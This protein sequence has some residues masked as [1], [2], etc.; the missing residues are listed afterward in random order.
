[1]HLE[2]GSAEGLVGYLDSM[3]FWSK[4]EVEDLSASYALVL[5]PSPVRGRAA[6]A[7]RRSVPSPSCPAPT[8]RRC[9]RQPS[10]PGSG[11][12]RRCASPRAG[13]GS[14]ARPTTARSPTS[15]AG[16]RR[17]CTWTRAATA[18]R[19]RWRGC[20]TWGARRAGW[21]CCTSTAP[22]RCCPRTATPSILDDRTI[23]TVTTSA[24]HYELGPIALALVKRSTPA[25]ATSRRRRCRRGPGGRRRGLSRWPGLTSPGRRS[26][27]RR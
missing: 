18:A 23:G 10:R 22:T 26:P 24:R 14:A 8:S 17:R 9:S 27:G 5:T 15:W 21:C 19:R 13:R 20:T 2:P 7:R 1:M 4:V 11:R 16:S 3:R 25:D 6:A 12:W